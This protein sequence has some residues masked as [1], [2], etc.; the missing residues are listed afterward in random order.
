MTA[1]W[2][3]DLDDVLC[4]TPGWRTPFRQTKKLWVQ[5]PLIQERRPEWFA[6][7]PDLRAFI[8]ALRAA[9]H[10]IAIVTGRRP[11]CRRVTADWLDRWGIGVDHLL[12]KP[13][14]EARSTPQYKRDVVGRLGCAVFVDDDR[15]N[16]EALRTLADCV[17]VWWSEARREA[18]LGELAAL[19]RRLE[20]RMV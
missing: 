16:V 13:A 15:Q 5:V 17:P 9:G 18:V 14:I 6:A 4:L 19:R 10:G 7:D 3:F 2:G 12:F 1:L 11:W 8:G 20:D